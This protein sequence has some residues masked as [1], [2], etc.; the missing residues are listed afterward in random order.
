[1]GGCRRPNVMST[2]SIDQRRSNNVT[3]GKPW[4]ILQQE[5]LC[6]QS[7]GQDPQQDHFTQHLTLISQHHVNRISKVPLRREKMWWWT[8][9]EWQREVRLSRTITAWS[10]RRDVSSW[11]V[12]MTTM[13]QTIWRFKS[14][15]I[16]SKN[17]ESLSRSTVVSGSTTRWSS[18]ATKSFSQARC[19]SQTIGLSLDT[20]ISTPADKVSTGS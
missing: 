1:M 14:Q 13:I 15:S 9:L 5:P 4:L 11:C 19:F 16:F 2:T 8:T 3:Q 18:C 17:P 7:I 12:A 20:M 6:L 10:W